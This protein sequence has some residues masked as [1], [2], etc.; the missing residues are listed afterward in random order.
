VKQLAALEN[1]TARVAAADSE[2]E[3]AE[4]K[5]TDEEKAAVPPSAAPPSA[6]ARKQ[7]RSSSSVDSSSSVVAK[8]GETTGKKQKKFKEKKLIG[9]DTSTGSETETSTKA[10]AAAGGDPTLA[11][12]FKQMLD[13]RRRMRRLRQD[14]E[15]VRLLCELIR[16]REQRKRDLVTATMNIKYLELN[17]FAYFLR[18]VMELL[19]EQDTQD[20]FGEPVDPAEVPD[21]LG[22]FTSQ[23]CCESGSVGSIPYVFGPPV[24]ESG[25]GFFADPGSQPHIFESLLTI[26]WV[27]SSIILCKLGQIFFSPVQNEYNFQFCDFCG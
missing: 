3:A 10:K 15:R 14:L 2:T 24:S 11:A 1:T 8:E 5:T 20:I 6:P 27:E 9:R 22:E 7:N 19:V 26:F 18:M 21:Y 23:R 12:A 17:P 16:K 25:V 13:E 4:T